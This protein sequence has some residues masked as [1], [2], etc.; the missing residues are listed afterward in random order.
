MVDAMGGEHMRKEKPAG[1][2]EQPARIEVRVGG[3]VSMMVQGDPAFVLQA[4]KRIQADLH[5]S[6][7][8]N[9]VVDDKHAAGGTRILPGTPR[10]TAPSERVLWLYRD[11]GEVTEVYVVRAEP[12]DAGPLIKSYGLAGIERVFVEDK[13]LRRVIARGAPEL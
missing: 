13:R 8:G 5:V 10:P 7:E 9:P 6:T 3:D 1:N 4:L 2:V 12:L 11:Q